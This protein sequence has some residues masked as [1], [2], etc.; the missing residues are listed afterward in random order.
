MQVCK[1][2]SKRVCKYESMQVCK[3]A[4]MQVS[5]ISDIF[6]KAKRCICPLAAFFSQQLRQLGIKTGS[7][8]KSE[9]QA[10]QLLFFANN[11]T[12]YSKNVDSF[13]NI[14]NFWEE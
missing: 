6:I 10:E 4:S 11:E 5:K 8:L 2:A 3:C 12:N 1:Y 7:V 9:N 14:F 13:F